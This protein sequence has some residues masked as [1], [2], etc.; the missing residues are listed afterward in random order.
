MWS[1]RC[2]S[3]SRLLPCANAPLERGDPST[4]GRRSPEPATPASPADGLGCQQLRTGG[5][6]PTTDPAPPARRPVRMLAPVAAAP[7]A[8]GLRVLYTVLASSRASFPSHKAAPP[9]PPPKS[10]LVGRL[11]AAVNRSGSVRQPRC[12]CLPTQSTGPS[13]IDDACVRQ[14]SALSATRA[15]SRCRPDR[16]AD[17]PASAS[18]PPKGRRPAAQQRPDAVCQLLDNV[19]PAS[20]LEQR[21][22]ARTGVP[23]C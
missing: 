2:H 23:L 21:G 5:D 16:D 3:V 4:R 9:I 20:P 8:S 12:S 7:A 19:P 15:L 14:S 11:M 1:L 10:D 18:K 17:R 13:T 22:A 6:L